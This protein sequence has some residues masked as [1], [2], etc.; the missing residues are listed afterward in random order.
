MSSLLLTPTVEI[1]KEDDG[2]EE[3]KAVC[4][5]RAARVRLREWLQ[6]HSPRN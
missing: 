6:G 1:K 5:T 3:E 2:N 4:P